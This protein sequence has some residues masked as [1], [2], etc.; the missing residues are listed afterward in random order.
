MLPSSGAEHRL[1]RERMGCFTRQ[2][3]HFSKAKELL[4]RKGLFCSSKH[5]HLQL[6]LKERAFLPD[7]HGLRKCR[8]TQKSRR[9]VS[10]SSSTLH[11]AGRR[12]KVAKPILPASHPYAEDSTQVVIP[13]QHPQPSELCCL[14]TVTDSKHWRHPIVTKNFIAPKAKHPETKQL[15]QPL[16]NIFWEC[17]PEPKGAWS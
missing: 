5:A 4:K 13:P 15:V 10:G 6:K 12:L 9:C 11:T 17:F 14:I 8:G 3:L 7:K 1:H 16:T 2:G